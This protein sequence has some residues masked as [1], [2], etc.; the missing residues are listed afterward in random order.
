MKKS[1][2]L[3]KGRYDRLKHSNSY[4]I[5]LYLAIERGQTYLEQSCGFG[6]VAVR[7]MKHF[8]DVVTLHALQ[9]KRIIAGWGNLTRKHVDGQIMTSD[10][11]VAYDKGMLDGIHHF[12]HIARPWIRQEQIPCFGRQCRGETTYLTR[13]P[14]DKMLGKRKY[15]FLALPKGR[16]FYSEHRQA[17]VEVFAESA[18]SYLFLQIAVGGR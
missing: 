14:I 4:S 9:V 18:S 5:F 17:E 12:A 13:I 6:L 1:H 16:Q 15:V 11:T 3:W 8:D 2:S 10:F 7:M